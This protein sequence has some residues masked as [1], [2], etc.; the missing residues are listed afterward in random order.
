M[1]YSPEREDPG[2]KK[3]KTET[4][5]KVVGGNNFFQ[6]LIMSFMEEYLKNSS[7]KF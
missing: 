2:N 1:A 5:P 3:Y 7:S 4:I 6:K